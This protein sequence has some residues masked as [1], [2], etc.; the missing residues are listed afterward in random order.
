MRTL[1][2]VIEFKQEAPNALFTKAQA[3]AVML[4][5]LELERQQPENTQAE[6]TVLENAMRSINFRY[7]DATETQTDQLLD[8]LGVARLTADDIVQAVEAVVFD[9]E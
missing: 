2:K 6:A 4:R 5:L 8:S 1:N 9:M 3:L 7:L